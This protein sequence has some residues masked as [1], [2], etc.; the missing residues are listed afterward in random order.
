[1]SASTARLWPST[2]APTRRSR[3]DLTDALDAD[4]RGTVTIR[5]DNSPTDDVR[6]LMG[7]HTMFGGLYREGGT[8]RARP[9]VH[10]DVAHHHPGSVVDQTHLDD[11][12]ARTGGRRPGQTAAEPFDGPVTV[13]VLDAG[14]APVSTA[15]SPRPSTPV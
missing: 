13:T 11:D 15:G 9:A 12:S 6:P 2:A 7:D 8:R 5:T 10:I 4:G 3:A 14:G 1:M